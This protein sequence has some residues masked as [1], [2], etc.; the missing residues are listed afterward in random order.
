MKPQTQKQEELQQKKTPWNGLVLGAG[1]GV[2]ARLRVC[3]CWDGGSGLSFTRAKTSPVSVAY[4][5]SG[6]LGDSLAY[7]RINREKNTN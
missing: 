4:N 1:G 7:Q 6:R 5:Y 2:G 3:V